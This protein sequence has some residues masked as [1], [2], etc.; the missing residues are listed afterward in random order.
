MNP[1]HHPPKKVTRGTR[2]CRSPDSPKIP[3]GVINATITPETTSDR[4][5][6]KAKLDDEHDL[7]LSQALRTLAPTPVNCKP[8]ALCNPPLNQIMVKQMVA[9]VGEYLLTFQTEDTNKTKH[10]DLDQLI[11]ELDNTSG[12]CAIT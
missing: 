4:S 3:V 6:K 8:R 9:R 10:L 5:T 12:K 7:R 1:Y 11:R 2:R